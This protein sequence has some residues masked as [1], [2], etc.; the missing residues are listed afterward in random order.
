MGSFKQT[1]KTCQ[2]LIFVPGD[3]YNRIVE[4]GRDH[5]CSGCKEKEN[6]NKEPHWTHNMTP[7]ESGIIGERFGE[8]R[9]C[10]DCDYGESKT[11]GGHQFDIELVHICPYSKAGELERERLFD[12]EQEKKKNLNQFLKH[13]QIISNLKHSGQKITDSDWS[14]FNCYLELVKKDREGEE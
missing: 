2:T 9:V 3:D 12:K 11:V 10:E 14:D 8:S 5:K 13:A 6:M 1:M 7:W 4:C